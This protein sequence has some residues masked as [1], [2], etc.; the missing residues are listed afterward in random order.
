MLVHP[1]QLE[2]NCICHMVNIK[3]GQ[4]METHA[5]VQSC[6]LATKN[7][8]LINILNSPLKRLKQGTNAIFPL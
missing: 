6:I 8:M 1:K 4:L 3:V 2:L 7:T 5:M